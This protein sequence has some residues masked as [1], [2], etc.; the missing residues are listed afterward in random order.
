MRCTPMRDE[1][2]ILKVIMQYFWEVAPANLPH[3][4]GV[5]VGDGKNYGFF[6]ITVEKKSSLGGQIFLRQSL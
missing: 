1:S 4:A 3:R 6:V 2:F 5:Q